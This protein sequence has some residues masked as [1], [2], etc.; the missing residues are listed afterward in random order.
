L[1]SEAEIVPHV[2]VICS[3]ED[4]C[5]RFW[6]PPWTLP[7]ARSISVRFSKNGKF[8]QV[9][10]TG[11]SDESHAWLVRNLLPFSM[12]LQG[13]LMLHASAVRL[14]AGA[15]GFI[16]ESG[17]GKSTLSAAFEDMAHQKLSDDLLACKFYGNHV[18]VIGDYLESEVN[19]SAI[20]FLHRDLSATQVSITHI[21]GSEYIR[22]LLKN[23]FSEVPSQKLWQN[24][25]EL[26]A[27]L[28]QI[29][30]A[31]KVV[32]PDDMEKLPQVVEQIAEYFGEDLR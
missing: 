28:A 22:S 31:C 29:V 7:N 21:Q 16:A 18:N 27:Q 30:T 10:K 14:K 24:M 6:L 25:F 19:L 13:Q 15:V 3:N 8:V 23:S 26:H 12:G 4:T 9:N 11:N 2:T 20:C 32:L 5:D 17:V 1:P